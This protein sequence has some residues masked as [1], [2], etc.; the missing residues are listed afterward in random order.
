M[1]EY[2]GRGDPKRSMQLLWRRQ[3]APT[4]GPKPKLALDDIVAA[5]IALA[6]EEGLASVTMRKV[7]ERLGTGTMSLYTHVPSKGELLDLMFEM[8]IVDVPF[9]APPGGWRVRLEALARADWD[10]YQRHPWL[11]GVAT[12]RAPMGPNSLDSYELVL[13][14]VDGIGLDG[15]EMIGVVMLVAGYVRGAAQ[16][17]ADAA[18]AERA[19]GISDE[20]WWNARSALLDEVWDPERFPVTTRVSAEYEVVE[21]YDADG[22]IRS[23]LHQEQ[24]DAFEFGLARVLDGIEALVASKQ[25]KKAKP[26]PKGR[27]S[28]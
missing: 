27:R 3:E 6:D 16:A 9:E 4:R 22:N 11:L 21:T 20:D 1:A 14:Q 7:A 28:S 19:T 17:V 8:A 12:T 25:P 15:R 24:L 10:L 26:A 2:T 23:Y 18:E 5:A 13:S